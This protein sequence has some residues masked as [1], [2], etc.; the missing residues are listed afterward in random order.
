MEKCRRGDSTRR[1]RPRYYYNGGPRQLGPWWMMASL[2]SI[3]H[4]KVDPAPARSTTDNNFLDF[5]STAYEDCIDAPGNGTSSLL[6][7]FPAWWEVL[8]GVAAALGE[9][10]DLQNPSASSV[11]EKSATP[12][13][14]LSIAGILRR[15]SHTLADICDLEDTSVRDVQPAGEHGEKVEVGSIVASLQMAYAT[16]SEM[17][18]QQRQMMEH[19]IPFSKRDDGYCDGAA[20]LPTPKSGTHA[21]GGFW[22]HCWATATDLVE[23]ADYLYDSQ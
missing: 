12:T 19:S 20:K 14:A 5:M 13:P 2:A 17:C 23:G 18:D 11:L 1:S 15:V 6:D 7:A 4:E 22:S 16:A 8:L 21:E 10:S 3:Q 9:M